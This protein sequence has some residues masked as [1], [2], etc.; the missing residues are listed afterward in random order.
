MTLDREFLAAAEFPLTVD[1][2]IS[3]TF[4]NIAFLLD[5]EVEPDVVYSPQTNT[6]LSVFRR[7]S[8]GSNND[9]RAR[10]V[11]PNLTLPQAPV[12]VDASADNSTNPRVARSSTG[13]FL[14][15]WQEIPSGGGASRIMGRF[16]TVNMGQA[17][18][19]G[20]E[21]E[22]SAAAA[23]ADPKTD[24]RVGFC[25]ST[26]RWLVVWK[27]E[28]AADPL[29]HDILGV[30]VLP[31][32]S[33]SGL[34]NIDL[35]PLNSD[36]SPTVQQYSNHFMMGVAYT[37]RTTP[38]AQG[39]LWWTS[40][41]TA[42]SNAVATPAAVASASTADD[43]DFPDLGYSNY[44]TGTCFLTWAVQ[45][46]GAGNDY[47]IM[48]Q[49]LTP[50]D[51]TFLTPF[52][53][54]AGAFHGTRPRNAL[55]SGAQGVF[56]AVSY[57][58][59]PTFPETPDDTQIETVILEAFLDPPFAVETLLTGNSTFDDRVPAVAFNTNTYQVLVAFEDEFVSDGSDTDVRARG[60][61]L[62]A[63]GP[64]LTVASIT[65]VPA[66]PVQG[67]SVTYQVVIDNNGNQPTAAPFTVGFFRHRA[68]APSIGSVPDQELEVLA[69]IPAGGSTTLNFVANASLVPGDYRAWAYVDRR[70]GASDIAE[71]VE[72]NNAGPGTIGQVVTVVNAPDLAVTG[73]TMQPSAP[74]Q[75]GGVAF[76]VTVRNQGSG[77]SAACTLSFWRTH[78]GEPLPGSTPDLT[79]AIPALLAGESVTLTLATTVA[80]PGSFTA[81]AVADFGATVPELDDSNNGLSF[82]WTAGSELNA[83]SL[84]IT[85]PSTPTATSPLPLAGTAD[86]DVQLEGV[87]WVN[88][89]TGLGGA[90]SGLTNW[91][92]DITLRRGT[93]VITVVAWDAA[94]N[95]TT[96]TVTVVYDPADTTN[97]SVAITTPVSNAAAGTPATVAGTASD[98]VGV[99]GI[100]WGNEAT[101][102]SGRLTPG[103]NWT[104]DIPLKAGANRIV[105][106]VSDLAGNEASATRTLNYAP[107]AEGAAPTIMVTTPAPPPTAVV[108]VSPFAVI[109]TA[110][111][112][113]GISRV[114]WSNAAS[115]ASGVAQ[116]ADD[117][118]A[119]VPLLLGTNLITVTAEDPFGNAASAQVTLILIPAAADAIPPLVL[120]QTPTSESSFAAETPDVLL[121]GL[122]ADNDAVTSVVWHNAATGQTGTAEGATVWSAVIPTA[123]GPN[124]VTV[125]AFD[126]SG[127]ASVAS[128]VIVRDATQVT[129]NS[130]SSEKCGLTG[131]EALLL[132]AAF[133]LRSVVKQRRCFTTVQGRRWR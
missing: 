115:G 130:S 41:D 3:G 27:Q 122:A 60:V 113:T 50:S 26:Q 9:I 83:P 110:S 58:T 1:P 84:V 68:S 126:T 109:G 4:V 107:A 104:V 5:L 80:A 11:G 12:E 51:G 46:G 120:I 100:R 99:T 52:S 98:D 56:L 93:N 65:A 44:D 30:T 8:A 34:I 92:A 37:K 66:V 79:T 7:V 116:G 97:P 31:D 85:P 53:V 29:D 95:H 90:A 25:A 28:S 38:G 123:T 114:T 72:E 121:G 61:R 77:A 48:G 91:T 39:D 10:I 59:N 117:W 33:R 43:E 112:A 15:V 67:Q 13:Q 86:D 45:T 21:F 71:I 6:Y 35:D 2:L 36:E 88:A 18:V 132:M 133:A 47:N 129:Y 131:L 103:A 57:S 73:I 128:I 24:P 63:D 23:P 94:G 78:V 19:S 82:A 42:N 49:G 69:P 108:D 22:I 119:D 102:A 125:T 70:L 32:G 17:A 54:E 96:A 87:T 118:T 127:N 101:G 106:T 62:L 40:V 124:P 111:D 76:D 55:F 16:V 14:V 105:V 20:S 74:V 81:W 89:A 64:D 75:G